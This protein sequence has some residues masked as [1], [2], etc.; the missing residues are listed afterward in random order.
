VPGD[1]REIQLQRAAMLR[2]LEGDPDPQPIRPRKSL[3]REGLD[4]GEKYLLHEEEVPRAGVH[5]SQA[6]ARV[7][8]R[9]GRPWV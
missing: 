6:L 2:L 5:V 8:A 9:D 3:L 1:V 7:R 4:A